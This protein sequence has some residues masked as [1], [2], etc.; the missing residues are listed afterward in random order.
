MNTQ[1]TQIHKLH[2]IVFADLPR[3]KLP[4]L[5]VLVKHGIMAN[6]EAVLFVYAMPDARALVDN[7]QAQFPL[8]DSDTIAKQPGQS[9]QLVSVST[10]H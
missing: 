10:W 8:A 2:Q 4:W 1:C 6:P 7:I 3:G 9:Q 5:Q